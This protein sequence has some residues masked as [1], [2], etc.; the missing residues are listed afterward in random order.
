M[1]V[2]VVGLGTIGTPAIKYIRKQEVHVCGYDL[3]ER[4]I[5]DIETFTEW[6]KVPKSDIYV[7]AVPSDSVEDACKEISN[8]DKDSLISIES[9]VK[10]GTCRKISRTYNLQ[11]LVHCPH[12]YWVENPVDHGIKQP[13]VMGAINERSLEKGLEFYR[14]LNIPLYVCPTIEIAEICK[15]AENAYRFVQIAFAEELR[16]VCG[17]TNINFDEVRKACNTKWNVE[18]L[19]AREGIVGSC[20]SKDIGYLKI[21]IDNV[22]LIEGAILTD[23]IYKRWIRLF[24]K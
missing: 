1:K 12:R 8:K 3:V 19:E 24:K 20:L 15:I 23:D 21:L 2:C 10:V 18:V 11:N 16:R 6:K 7:V 9:T 14:S 13:R 17:A 5:D 22:P 4:S